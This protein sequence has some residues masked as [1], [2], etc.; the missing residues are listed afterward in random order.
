MSECFDL[1][2]RFNMLNSSDMCNPSDVLNP[3][4]MSELV[5]ITKSA[6]TAEPFTTI[7]SFTTAESFDMPYRSERLICF[8]ILSSFDKLKIVIACICL[9]VVQQQA[10]AQHR[11]VKENLHSVPAAFERPRAGFISSKPA[12]NWEHSLLSGNGTMGAMVIGEPYKETI[13]CSHA[14]LYL[15]QKRSGV[16]FEQQS[17]LPEIKKLLLAGKYSEAAQVTAT[18]RKEQGFDD[19]RDPFIP[20]FDL[21]IDQGQG[22]LQSYQRAVNF[23]TGEASVSWKDDKGVFE[24][25]LF[26]S[27]ADSVIVLSI[28][29]DKKINCVL[30]FSQRPAEEAQRKFVK[31]GMKLLEP[32]AEGDWLSFKGV[33]NYQYPG[34]LKGYAGVG[35]L[36][37]KGG[38][39]TIENG[40]L[41]VKDADEVLLLIRIKPGY[42][43]METLVPALKAELQ[44]PAMESY[45][46]LLQRH[47]LIHG[48]LFNRVKLDLGGMESERKLSAEAL[49]ARGNK[50]VSPALIERVFD[51]GRYNIISSTGVLPP[52]LQGIWSGTWTGPWSSGFTLDGNL[53]AAISILMPGNT[54]ELM[55]GFFDFHEHLMGEYR[56][57]AKQLFGVR[58]I[59]IP[60]QVTTRGLE[61][62]F[63]A[64]W[65]LSYWTGAAGWTANFFN[66]YYLYTGDRN[67]LEQHAYPFMKEAAL[68]YEDF[69]K[70]GDNGKLLFIPSYSPENNPKDIDAQATINATMDIM[71]AR[72]LLSNCITAANLLHKDAGKIRIWKQMLSKMPGY[73]INK[74]GVLKEWLWPGLDDN[75][76]HRHASQLYALYDGLSPDFNN[77]PALVKAA[78]N[79]LDKKMAFRYAE[80]GGEMAFGLV[81]LGS[82]A[83][84][85]GDAVK[86]AE[87]TNWLASTYWSD[88]M[89]SYHN[90]K[91]LFNTDISGGL[92]YLITQLL[93]FA[94]PGEVYVLHALPAEWQ[95]GKVEGL[96][97]KGQITMNR[98]E[99]NGR[100]VA[101]ELTSA[102]SQQLKVHCGKSVLEVSIKAGEKKKLHFTR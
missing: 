84:H 82:A 47:V 4:G 62:D 20:A 102:V 94:E 91:S 37:Q 22:N 57:E 10:H 24:R 100:N 9:F 36:I 14:R 71:I 56:Q 92:P 81:Q 35:K 21:N 28:K 13:I 7:E 69:L 85:L 26:V 30:Q 49:I 17:A 5:K 59:H 54:A 16:I 6:Y 86:A 41:V 50:K 33:F 83:A 29:G 1:L 31:E 76:S 12:E 96:L 89:G 8:D 27:R 39:H 2:K 66:D 77:N 80:G 70:P 11:L 67:F 97:L 64:I 101:I 99:W 58:G 38:V 42:G 18:L 46:Q 55:K 32:D 25:K 72:Q 19:P 60:A 95:N 61:T 90:V 98:L 93:C 74:E 68:F 63:G 65:C 40:T 15:P 73:E 75:Y 78:K 87:L 48:A 51:A 44:S 43:D 88:G 52:N 53:P 79:L 3:F 45:Q 34:G 23:E